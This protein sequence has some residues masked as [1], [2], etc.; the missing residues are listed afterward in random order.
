L[1]Q[2]LLRLGLQEL[3]EAVLVVDPSNAASAKADELCALTIKLFFGDTESDFRAS[4]IAGV[5]FVGVA[6]GQRSAAFLEAAGAGTVHVNLA[7][8]WQA[9]GATTGGKL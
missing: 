4:A 9:H 1:P 6:S 7:T 2:Q 8:A 3:F 5:P